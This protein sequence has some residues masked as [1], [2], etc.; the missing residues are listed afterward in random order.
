M[1][2]LRAG[3]A[4][5]VGQIRSNNEGSFLV[6]PDRDLYGVAD[7]MGGHQGGEVASAMAVRLAE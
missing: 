2:T 6:V 5:D 4:T 7:G 1:T 3:H